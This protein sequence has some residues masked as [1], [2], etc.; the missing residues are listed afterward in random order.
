MSLSNANAGIILYNTCY[1]IFWVKLSC[2]INLPMTTASSTSQSSSAVRRGRGTSA[3]G[4]ATQEG[5]W[6]SYF[7]KQTHVK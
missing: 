2:F 5:N 1:N 6:G 4:A 7:Y 3:V